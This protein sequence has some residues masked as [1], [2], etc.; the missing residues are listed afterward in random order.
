MDDGG[1]WRIAKICHKLEYLNIA[2]HTEI[3][4]HSICG[5]I[6]SSPKLRHLDIS[7]CEITD[8]TIKEVADSCLNLKYLNLEGCSNISK[9]ALDQLNPN[10]HVEI[11]R[12]PFDNQAV[13]E[14]VIR[15][16]YNTRHS[17]DNNLNPVL[18]QLYQQL[19]SNISMTVDSGA[20]HSTIAIIRQAPRDYSVALLDDQA[21]W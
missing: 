15:R 4:E 17:V 12:G 20:D 11:F 5:I 9:E 18:S 14:Q 8:M 2:Y 13:I 19:N 7:F 16:L 10:T 3:T 6:R 1:L 21:E